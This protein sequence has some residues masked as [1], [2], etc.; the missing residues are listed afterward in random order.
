MIE[1]GL[2]GEV[3]GEEFRGFFEGRGVGLGGR[4]GGK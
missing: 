2:V 3:G 1:A 4:R